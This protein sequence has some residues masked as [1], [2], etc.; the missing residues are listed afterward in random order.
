MPGFSLQLCF[1]VCLWDFVLEIQDPPDCNAHWSWRTWLLIAPHSTLLLLYML[2]FVLAVCYN[3][4]LHL[5]VG[6]PFD[7]QRA[8]LS[9]IRRTLVL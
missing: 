4:Q 1:V 6:H 7:S 9:I 3:T 2:Q 8:G 5:A